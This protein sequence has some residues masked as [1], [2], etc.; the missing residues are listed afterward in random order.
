MAAG[1]SELPLGRPAPGGPRRRRYSRRRPA[2]PRTGV[3]RQGE[4]AGRPRGAASACQTKPWLPGLPPRRRAAAR[5]PLATGAA[6]RAA[7]EPR[8]QGG[9]EARFG[10]AGERR[11]GGG[12]ESEMELTAEVIQTGERPGPECARQAHVPSLKRTCPRCAQH[13]AAAA[14]NLCRLRKSL[15]YGYFSRHARISHRRCH[16]PSPHP[17]RA[18]TVNGPEGP[19]APT[20]SAGTWIEV[21]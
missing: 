3:G 8:R 20:R 9:V 17:S 1:F 21:S 6:A 10:R 19:Q 16:G 12:R 15:S 2:R 11:Q 18:L 13:L 7:L 4:G 5:G 14:A